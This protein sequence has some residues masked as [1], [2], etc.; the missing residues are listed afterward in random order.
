MCINCIYF[1]KLIQYANRIDDDMRTDNFDHFVNRNTI[2][3]IQYKTE[4]IIKIPCRV[5][6]VMLALP[7]EI[8]NNHVTSHA[9]PAQH[10]QLHDRNPP[11]SNICRIS[12]LVIKL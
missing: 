5:I 6:D 12:S 11:R 9:A 10:K 8:I 2:S 3:S 7:P 4:G 1:G